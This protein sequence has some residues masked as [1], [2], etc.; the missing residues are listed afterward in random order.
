MKTLLLLLMVLVMTS[1]G[2]TF[3][4]CE[5]VHYYRPYYQ[6]VYRQIYYHPYY[7]GGYG[8]THYGGSVH[9]SH[10]HR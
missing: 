8:H 5:P 2:V 6:P 1:C 7:N 3:T 10:G 9:Y 4:P